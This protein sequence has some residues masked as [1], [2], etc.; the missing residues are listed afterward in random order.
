MASELLQPPRVRECPI[1]L[2]AAL[3]DARRIATHDPR[4]PVAALALEVTV[5]RVHVEERLLVGGARNRIDPEQWQPLLMS[6][7]QFYGRG[8]RLRASRLAEAPESHYAPAGV[9]V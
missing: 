9:Q 2:E 1:Q 4:M 3:A 7:R 8:P 5:R 6:F